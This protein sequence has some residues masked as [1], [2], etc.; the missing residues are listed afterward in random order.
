MKSTT[1]SRDRE[2]ITQLRRCVILGTPG[3]S[4]WLQT[5]IEKY[6]NATFI[7]QTYHDVM[8]LS[9]KH[10]TSLL[11]ATDTFPGGLS[12]ELITTIKKYLTPMLTICLLEQITPQTE[13]N[14]RATGLT[15]LGSYSVFAKHT[16]MILDQAS[17]RMLG[18]QEMVVGNK[19]ILKDKVVTAAH[20]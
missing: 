8:S 1:Y 5:I 10:K 12:Q 14:L 16:D 6:F 19:Y 15:F 9:P 20:P 18:L 11:L 7:V 3:D 13:I 2:Q 4:F 17:T